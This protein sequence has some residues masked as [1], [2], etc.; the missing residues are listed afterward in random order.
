MHL[1]EDAEL[2]RRYAAEKSEPAFAE[3]VRRHLDLVYSVAL[4]Q[5]GGDAHLAEDVAQEVFTALARKAATLAGRPVLGGWL[6]RTAQFSAIDIVRAENR[7]RARE[8][9]AHTMHELTANPGGAADWEKLRPTLDQAIGELK[10]DDRDA[11]VMRFFE[12]KSFADMGTRLRLSENAARMRVE[13]ALDKLHSALSRR[14]V[15][16]TAAAL[17]MA[18]TNQAGVAAPVGLAASVVTGAMGQAAM[19]G[20]GVATGH[21]VLRLMSTTNL[22]S[23]VITA[24]LVLCASLA[25]NAYL[26]SRSSVANASAVSR[27]AA[28]KS[29]PARASAV[30]LA[31]FTG[32]VVA[33]RDQL[34]AAGASEASIRG[35]IEGILRRRYREKLSGLRAERMQHSWWIDTS[36]WYQA[37]RSDGPPRFVDDKKLLREMVLDPLDQLCGPDPAE[38]AEQTARFEFLPAERRDAFVALERDYQAAMVRLSSAEQNSSLGT[39]L[40]R[41]HDEKQRQLLGALTPAERAEYDLHFSTTAVALRERMSQIGATEP[42]YRAIMAVVAGS[43][44][45]TGQNAQARGIFGASA[46]DVGVAQQ[47]VAALGYDRALDYVWAGAWEY[48]SYARVAQDA[49]LPA[50]TPARVLELAAETIAQAETIHSDASLTPAQK[51]AA[52]VALQQEVRPQLDALLPPDQQRRLPARTLGWF[53]AL[54]EGRYM[55]IP[56]T[57][58]GNTGGVMAGGLGTSVDSPPPANRVRSQFVVPRP[59]S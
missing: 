44:N 5:V 45:S 14:G 50:S 31:A 42:E 18:L 20:G 39:S 11:V 9:E 47:L 30:P 38:A 22:T 34:R 35:V 15:T 43:E 51:R 36:W 53:T 10:D 8:T 23:G 48:P 6:Y 49:G 21:S 28:P 56:T 26:L 58:A 40:Q 52:V 29:E 2:L 1:V 19:A 55:S 59:K 17:G 13:R 27:L 46:S 54:A 32:D 37:G 12:G 41:E 3:L 24:A 57:A 33:L 4:R 25:G 7:R 16:S